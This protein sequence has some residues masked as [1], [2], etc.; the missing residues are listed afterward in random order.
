[1]CMHKETKVILRVYVTPDER[2][3]LKQIAEEQNT[4]LSELIATATRKQY[5][6][7]KRKKVRQKTA[8]LLDNT[9]IANQH[10][11]DAGTDEIPLDAETGVSAL[12]TP[13][14]SVETHSS[15][16]EI[17]VTPEED[18]DNQEITIPD[19]E[20]STYNYFDDL[21]SK[22]SEPHLFTKKE[23][24]AMRKRITVIN[25]MIRD[26]QE[27]GNHLP[28]PVYAKLVEQKKALI[29]IAYP[30]NDNN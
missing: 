9:E 17:T 5:K 15:D 3:A 14:E 27:T 12:T 11:V 20:D 28:K 16:V 8:S 30:D 23:K 25:N 6:L 2:D 22:G 4:S 1:M 24:K 7:G 21:L 26:A 13:C 19:D 29:P 18:T 10:T